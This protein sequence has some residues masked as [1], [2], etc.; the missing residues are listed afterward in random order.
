MFRAI[1]G[2]LASLVTCCK[3]QEDPLEKSSCLFGTRPPLP[4]AELWAD[5]TMPNGHSPGVYGDR[6]KLYNIFDLR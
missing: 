3:R 1:F 6:N 5:V 2:K 4:S